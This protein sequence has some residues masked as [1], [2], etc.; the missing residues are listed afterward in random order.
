MPYEDIEVEFDVKNTGDRAGDEV[1]QLYV[2]DCV[3]SVT[4]YEKQLR[5]FERVHLE[6]G[7]TKRVKMTLRGDL[8]SLLDV[9]MQ[10]VVEPGYFDIMIGASSVDIR[11]KEKL[12]VLDDKGSYEEIGA[13]ADDVSV[14]RSTLPA[15]LSRGVDVT[16]PVKKDVKVDYLTITWGDDAEGCEFEI[17]TTIG[18]GQFLPVFGGVAEKGKSQ[19]CRFEA[20]TASE[21]RVAVTKGKGTVKALESS[22]LARNK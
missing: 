1:V 9:N 2:S 19:T 22:A 7:Q 5:G 15:T 6:P 8:L 10:R 16:F 17:L 14:V 12:L 18:G 13:Y 3:S 4:V 21:I 20:A 11:L